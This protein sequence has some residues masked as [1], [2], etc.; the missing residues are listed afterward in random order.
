[1]LY[2]SEPIRLTTSQAE[3]QVTVKIYEATPSDPG[4]RASQVV[5]GLSVAKDSP[6]DLVV[7]ELVRLINPSDR[8]FVPQ[9]GGP[10]GPTGLVR[11]GLPP[12]AKRLEPGLGL[13]P[14]QVFQFDR[15]FASLAPVPPGESVFR[16]SY[17]VPFQNAAEVLEQPLPYGA[18]LFRVMSEEGGPKVVSPALTFERALDAKGSKILVWSAHDLAPD[19]RVSIEL[20]D[21]P[22]PPAWARLAGAVA[23]P[24]VIAVLVALIPLLGV[25]WALRGRTRPP[26]QSVDELS[27]LDESS[28]KALVETLSELDKGFAEGRAPDS[29][30]ATADA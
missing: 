6:R 16:F 5:V 14:K 29:E 7:S 25:F 18:E 26:E 13:D 2:R 3:Q 11:F 19:T 20:S 15:G 24:W 9:A 8:T 27:L 22:V 21:L 10:G 30:Y 12:G 28:M 4:L 17:R 23:W 1:M